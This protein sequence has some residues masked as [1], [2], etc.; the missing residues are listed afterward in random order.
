MSLKI[1]KEL[2]FRCSWIEW[3]FKTSFSRL[4]DR[5]R[6]GYNINL[7]WITKSSQ[8]TPVPRNSTSLCKPCW[9]KCSKDSTTCPQTSSAASMRWVSI[10]LWRQAHRRHL[11]IFGRNHEWFGGRG[12]AN[13]EQKG[14]MMIAISRRLETYSNSFKYNTYKWLHLHWSTPRC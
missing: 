12:G 8:K 9:S 4:L 1:K 3:N 13:Y 14:E 2:W 7:R 5:L 10:Q 6:S 11:E